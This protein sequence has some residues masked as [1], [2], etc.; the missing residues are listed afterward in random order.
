MVILIGNLDLALDQDE[1]RAHQPLQPGA[2]HEVIQGEPG[3]SI[4]RPPVEAEAKAEAEVAAKKADNMAPYRQA[5]PIAETGVERPLQPYDVD[6]TLQDKGRTLD[7]PEVPQSTQSQSTL[8]SKINRRPTI[9]QV[10]SPWRH[11]ESLLYKIRLYDDGDE[12][13]G[14]FPRQWPKHECNNKFW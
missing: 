2:P 9:Q 6:G 3:V 11:M 4:A 7:P 5:R 10:A 8:R 12:D 14:E 1:N 13:R